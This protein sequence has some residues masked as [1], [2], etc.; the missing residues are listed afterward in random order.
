M[1][2]PS[3]Q[4]LSGTVAL[5]TGASRGI[6]AA[7]AAGLA[8]LGAHVVIAARDDA[9]LAATDDAIRA[10]G[11]EATLLPADLTKGDVTDQIGI[12]LY[13]RFGRLDILVH[14]AATVGRSMPVG[15]VEQS[16][17]EPAFGINATATWRLI[18]ACGG[19]LRDAPYG[20]AVVL[21]R[22]GAPAAYAGV[23]SASMAAR[24]ALVL[25]WAAEVARTRLRVN[26]FDPAM[27]S[28]DMAAAR[29]I[30][31]SLPAEMRHGAVVTGQI[32]A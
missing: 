24:R 9:G 14:A 16:D 13:E 29:L 7:T 27:L 30:A 23:V 3:T 26:L 15:Q 25:S 28:S 31:M 21:I 11:G 22:K 19:L 20:R 6:G 2:E 8:R 4:I 17:W 1:D 12:S 5:V 32:G 18:R 10:Q